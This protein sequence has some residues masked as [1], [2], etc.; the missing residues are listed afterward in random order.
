[1]APRQGREPRGP[2]SPQIRYPSAAGGKEVRKG[3]PGSHRIGTGA[4]LEVETMNR[5]EGVDSEERQG[6]VPEQSPGSRGRGA[7]V[8]QEA[9][10][11]RNIQE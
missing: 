3:W 7:E 10:R 11:Q 8:V 6:R 9:R 1:M 5:G 4:K 2:T